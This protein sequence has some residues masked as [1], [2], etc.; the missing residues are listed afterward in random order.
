MSDYVGVPNKFWFMINK[1][2]TFIVHDFNG[3]EAIDYIFASNFE[4]LEEDGYG[5]INE[6]C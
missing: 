1:I 4:F 6:L 2:D 3:N 5:L